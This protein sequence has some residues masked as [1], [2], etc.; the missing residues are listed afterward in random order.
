[1]M[2]DIR[3]IREDAEKISLELEFFIAKMRLNELMSTYKKNRK[4]A[5]TD[6]DKIAGAP[7]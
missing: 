3:R 2:R 5:K 1:M 4:T 7:A 6:A